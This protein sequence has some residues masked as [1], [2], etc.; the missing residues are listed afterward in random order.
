MHK[1]SIKKKY[2]KRST[3]KKYPKEMPEKRN[4]RKGRKL[5]KIQLPEKVTRII[6]VL[7]KEGFEAYAVG[8]CVRDTLLGREPGDWDI[9]TSADPEEVKGLFSHT[10]DTGIEHGTV[11]VMLGKDGYEVTTYRMDGEYEDCRHPKSVTFTKSLEEDLKRRDFTIN[12]MAYNDKEGLVDIFNGREDLENRIIRCVGNPDERFDEDALRI[13]RAFRFSAQL[14]FAIEEKTCYSAKQ[15]SKNLAKISAE[16]I[17]TELSKLLLSNHPDR[18]R[19][20]HENEITKV[21]LPEFDDLYEMGEEKVEK[22]IEMIK[23]VPSTECFSQKEV[24]MLKWAALLYEIKEKDEGAKKILQRMKFDNETIGK[25]TRLV[26][27]KERTLVDLSPAQM[28]RTI[29]EVGDDI[30]EMLFEL[31]GAEEY[32]KMRE[33]Y[34][35]IT[36]RGECTSLKQLKINGRDLLER[37]FKNGRDIGETLE[38]L[39]MQVIE[40]PELNE[41][42]KLFALIEER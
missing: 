7:E 19:I 39:L 13:L 21:I 26:R 25:V 16:R 36:E 42:E 27:E 32:K 41:R 23:R 2:Q 35:G 1:R 10:I 11:T 8:G 14:N 12:A 22:N 3:K 30:M 20:L 4:K 5:L 34:H 29:Y 17:R 37:G 28:R 15:K 24:L 18:L 40:E 33:M 6:D 38:W 9:T 31:K